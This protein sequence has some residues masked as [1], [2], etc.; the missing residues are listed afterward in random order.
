[1]AMDSNVQYSVIELC[2]DAPGMVVCVHVCDRVSES[3]LGKWDTATLTTIIIMQIRSKRTEKQCWIWITI[4]VIDFR[5]EQALVVLFGRVPGDGQRSVR[6][7]IGTNYVQL[8]ILPEEI[9]Q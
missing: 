4:N 1:M 6:H 9:S 3:D 5:S 2:H 7:K 8:N